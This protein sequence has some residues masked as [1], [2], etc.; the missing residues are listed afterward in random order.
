LFQLI[1]DLIDLAFAV[2]FQGLDFGVQLVLLAQLDS[3]FQLLTGDA[4]EILAFVYLGDFFLKRLLSVVDFLFD[5]GD[6]LVFLLQRRVPILSGGIVDFCERAVGSGPFANIDEPLLAG[7]DVDRVEDERD[8]LRGVQE[9]VVAVLANGEKVGD[10]PVDVGDQGDV[11]LRRRLL[12]RVAAVRRIL[13]LRG[14]SLLR[15]FVLRVLG[16]LFLR[17]LALQ[18]EQIFRR[19]GA[20]NLCGQNVRFSGGAPSVDVDVRS[21]FCT[22]LSLCSMF[23][24]IVSFSVSA[25]VCT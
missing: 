1:L 9:L 4:T 24:S 17:G 15:T 5:L 21:L 2:R 3:L 20:V 14:V 10:D 23:A 18:V 11:D 19:Q 16:L 12:F 6:E 13:F 7:Q 8:V 22:G 25:R